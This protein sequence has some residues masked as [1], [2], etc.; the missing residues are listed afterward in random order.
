M[1]LHNCTWAEVEGYV[2]RS[3]GILMPIGSTEQ[4]GPNGLIGTDAIC[5]EAIVG[6]AGDELDAL[7]APTIAVGMAQ[8]HMAFAGSMT[9]RPSTI[10]RVIQDS[11]TSLARHGF[12]HFYFVNAHGGNV[13][14]LTAA[15]DEV[16]AGK[17]LHEGNGAPLRCRTVNWWM[18]DRTRKLRDELYGAKEGAH[19]TPSEVALTQYLRPEPSNAS[20]STAPRRAPPHLPTPTITG[21]SFPMAAWARTRR[22]PRRRTAAACWTPVSPTW[23]RPIASLSAMARPRGVSLRVS[24]PPA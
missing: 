24:L 8:H 17:S 1:L 11:L 23:S 13:A 14:S 22:S 19:A 7:V 16:Y 5:A 21:P 2:A 12:T 15:F 20:P 18:G 4:H 10:L 6:H 3:T 9:L